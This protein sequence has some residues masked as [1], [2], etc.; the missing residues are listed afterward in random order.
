MN[1]CCSL[2]CKCGAYPA[3]EDARQTLIDQIV[4]YSES[5]IGLVEKEN[6]Y[7]NGNEDDFTAIAQ[8][9]LVNMRV[10]S[11]KVPNKCHS[12]CIL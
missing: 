2:F 7:D 8:P 9:F 12:R 3:N 11:F 1:I 10:P 4:R 6:V 5:L